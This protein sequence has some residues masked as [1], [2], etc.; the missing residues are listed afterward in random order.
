MTYLSRKSLLAPYFESIIPSWLHTQY[1]R[2]VSPEAGV[3][4]DGMMESVTWLLTDYSPA[5]V[6]SS[7]SEAGMRPADQWEPG[8]VQCWLILPR[9]LIVMTWAQC[10]NG[11]HV[12]DICWT[13]AV[14]FNEDDLISDSPPIVEMMISVTL[15][16]IHDH[17]SAQKYD[18]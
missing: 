10:H 1:S 9:R 13:P 16:E 15:T 6:T 7:Q 2:C 3:A 18:T 17:I 14:G 5:H 8:T 12:P 4:C 11:L